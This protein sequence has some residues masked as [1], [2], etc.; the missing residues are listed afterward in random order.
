MMQTI[1]F[2]GGGTLG[3][4]YPALSFIRYFKKQNPHFRIIFF[5]TNKDQK[6]SVLKDNPDIDQIYWFDVYGIPKKRTKLPNAFLKNIKSYQK[7]KEI[8]AKE[9]ISLSIGMGGYISGITILASAKLGINTVIHEQNSVLGFANRMVLKFTKIIF[10]SFKTT[11]V[12]KKYQYKI[13]W[14]GNPRYDEAKAYQTSMYHNTKQILI[15]SG[16]LGSKIM[17][18]KAITFLNSDESKSYTTTLITGPQYYDEVIKKV[19]PGYHYQIHAF[20]NQMLEELSRANIVISRAGSTTLFEILAMKKVAIIIPS[21]NVTKNHQ[22]L[23]ALDFY[24]EGLIELVTENDLMEHSLLTY[25][26]KI[27]RSFSEISNHLNEYQIDNVSA[28]FYQ[29]IKPFIKEVNQ[30]D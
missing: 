22:Y 5:A 20:T 23:N 3:H 17:N 28:A 8:I 14:I 16:S 18:D 21:P 2:S 13:K 24:N 26:Q 6:Y 12:K 1:L 15:T 19:K 7:I 9:K 10:T 30:N 25:I 29:E 11:K 4:I 27:E